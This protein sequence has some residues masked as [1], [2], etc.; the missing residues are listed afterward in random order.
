MSD[1]T[2]VTV[3]L[4]YT[5]NLGNFQSL[6]VDLGCTDYVREG[7]NTD[8]A[9]TRVYDFVENKVMEKIEEAKREM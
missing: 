6:R 7:E 2:T 9:M 5:L 1:K 4:G 8:S 3:N